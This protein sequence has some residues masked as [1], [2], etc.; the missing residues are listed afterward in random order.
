[1]IREDCSLHDTEK[2]RSSLAVAPKTRHKAFALAPSYTPVIL[3]IPFRE[4]PR[5]DNRLIISIITDR[6]LVGMITI[7][8][9]H[10]NLDN[11]ENLFEALRCI[12]TT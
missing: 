7:C 4:I 9:F 1:M 11:I 6:I 10:W 8:T 2:T 5:P 12:V 3:D